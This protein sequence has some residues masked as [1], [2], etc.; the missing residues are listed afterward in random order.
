VP[1]SATLEFRSSWRSERFPLAFRVVWSSLPSLARNRVPGRRV[2][3][4]RSG[5][6]TAMFHDEPRTAL[7][8]CVRPDPS[9]GGVLFRQ[10]HL[11]LQTI[12]FSRHPLSSLIGATSDRDV[13]HPLE[14][15][16]N[17]IV[18][19]LTV[20]SKPWRGRK[21]MRP[22]SSLEPSGIPPDYRRIPMYCGGG[23]NAQSWCFATRNC[24]CQ[25]S[26]RQWDLLIRAISH[27]I[28]H[29]LTGLAPSL[30]RWNAR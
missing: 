1:I 20:W 14:E 11:A 26:R 21:L 2:R 8:R 5:F 25:R 16:N 22:A 10:V 30:L 7:P 23:W 24:R 4:H 6:L 27:A 29:P 17:A 18:S 15:R 28:F 13:G 19:G 9:R 3:A 12:H